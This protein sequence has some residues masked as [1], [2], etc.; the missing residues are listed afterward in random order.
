M[1]WSKN[2]KSFKMDSS[3][4]NNQS[5][6]Q[7]VKLPNIYSIGENPSYS[8]L[9]STIENISNKFRPDLKKIKDTIKM[10]DILIWILYFK[11]AFKVINKMFLFQVLK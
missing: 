6:S 4:I 7:A 9:S 2:K 1:S 8:N 10:F 11:K 3:S 5:A